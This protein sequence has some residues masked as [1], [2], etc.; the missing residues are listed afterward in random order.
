MLNDE[1]CLFYDFAYQGT[2]DR[3]ICAINHKILWFF[4]AGE[5]QDKWDRLLESTKPH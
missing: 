4:D 5:K 2:K 3:C 1:A